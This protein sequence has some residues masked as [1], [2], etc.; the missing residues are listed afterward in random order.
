MGSERIWVEIRDKDS[1]LVLHRK[2]LTPAQDYEINYLQGRL[3]LN[4]PLGSTAADGN[5]VLTSALSGNPAYLVA[6]YEFC[7]GPHCRE[8]HGAGGLA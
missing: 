4:S 6:T 7:S 5:L 1:G 2:Q 3:L 8:Q